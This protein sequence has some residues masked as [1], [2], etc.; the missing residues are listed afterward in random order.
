M[1]RVVCMHAYREQQM[2]RGR[3]S[4]PQDPFQSQGWRRRRDKGA[5]RAKVERRQK[6]GNNMRRRAHAGTAELWS[7]SSDGLRSVCMFD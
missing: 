3:V 1:L 5:R 4:V 2:Q 7:S 6:N